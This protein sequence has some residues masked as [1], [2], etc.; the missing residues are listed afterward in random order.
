MFMY[1]THYSYSDLRFFVT[2]LCTAVQ[3]TVWYL[4][5]LPTVPVLLVLT[6]HQKEQQNTS[7]SLNL[8]RSHVLARDE[9][10]FFE[11]LNFGK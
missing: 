6:S 2:L 1:S 9:A 11:I 4:Y 7:S 8:A 10:D 3:G 5:I